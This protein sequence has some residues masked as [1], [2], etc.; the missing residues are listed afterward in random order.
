M[1]QVVTAFVAMTCLA[2]FAPDNAWGQV[3]KTVTVGFRNQ[4][5]SD[6]LVQGFTIVNGVQ[7]LGQ[8]VTI[9]KGGIAFELNVP[10]GVRFY[11]IVDAKSP[12]R[13]LLLREPVTIQNRDASFTIMPS[14][15]DPKRVVLVPD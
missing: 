6:L 13:P 3:P 9:R 4:T 12:V 1:R 5:N 15:N 7:R 10:P 2:L 14:P 11:T 8:P